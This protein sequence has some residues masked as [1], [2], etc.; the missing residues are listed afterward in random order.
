VV[1]FT[2]SRFNRRVR[3]PGKVDPTAVPHATA[4]ITDITALPE[5]EPRSSSPYPSL[6]LSLYAHTHTH[7]HTN[8]SKVDT[9]F[10]IE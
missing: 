8:V 10:H 6:S 1:S 4:E 7:T 9:E 2:P 5:T 3:A